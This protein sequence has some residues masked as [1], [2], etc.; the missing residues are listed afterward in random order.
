M[1]LFITNLLLCEFTK[2]PTV[3]GQ[4]YC[5][6]ASLGFAHKRSNRFSTLSLAAVKTSLLTSRCNGMKYKSESIL[7]VVQI[8][9]LGVDKI[10]CFYVNVVV[11]ITNSKLA[12]RC[13]NIDVRWKSGRRV[14]AGIRR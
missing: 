2:T 8:R 13:I 11:V 9:L 10:N 14:K 3:D 7:Q 4:V 12:L 1:R 5:D 6:R